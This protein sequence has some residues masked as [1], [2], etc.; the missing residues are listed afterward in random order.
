MAGRCVAL[1]KSARV[2]V[3]DLTAP[4]H[5]FS[6]PTLESRTAPQPPFE[7]AAYIGDVYHSS[8]S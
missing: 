5:N 3:R 2:G 7:I 8:S 4:P 6:D 1:E